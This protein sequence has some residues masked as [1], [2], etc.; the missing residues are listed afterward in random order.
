MKI[1]K[2]SEL[3]VYWWITYDNLNFDFPTEVE[4][5]LRVP[6]KTKIS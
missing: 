1:E 2:I 5:I 4:T 6:L 3:R